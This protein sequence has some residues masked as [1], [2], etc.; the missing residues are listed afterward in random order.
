MASTAEGRRLTE[1]HRIAQARLGRQAVSLMGAA[2]RII[3]PA[4]LDGTVEAWLRAAVP[5]VRAQHS[6]SARLAAAYYRRFRALEAR[7]TSQFLPPLAERVS[8]E[9]TIASL[10]TTGPARVRAATARGATIAQ[11]SRAGLVGAAGAAQR[12]ILDAGRNTIAQATTADPRALGWARALSGNACAFCQMLASRG[13]AYS[14]ESVA[15]EAHDRCSCGAEPVYS[16]D[17]AWPPGSREAR[18]LW[19]QAA[20]GEQDPLNAFRRALADT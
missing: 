4:D 1:A 8:V 5:I 18:D 7:T 2:W 12:L 6:G 15:F 17:A 19:D 13:P 3:D 14:E 20:V 9:R 16:T 10:T 11:A